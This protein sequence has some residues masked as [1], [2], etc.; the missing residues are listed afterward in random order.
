MH[1]RL[2]PRPKW[3]ECYNDREDWH[4]YQNV[5]C[6][7]SYTNCIQVKIGSSFR[8]L[9]FPPICTKFIQKWMHPVLAHKVWDALWLYDIRGWNFQA[10]ASNSFDY[11]TSGSLAKCYLSWHYVRNR[12]MSLNL[13][14]RLKK[15]KT[16]IAVLAVHWRLLN[17]WSE[18]WLFVR[19]RMKFISDCGEYV[20]NNFLHL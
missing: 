15:C 4:F 11:F 18:C 17:V 5:Y 20:E 2:K 14:M 16:R 7:G 10:I 3:Y 13:S 12:N 9:Y 6:L 19:C 1:R 8:V